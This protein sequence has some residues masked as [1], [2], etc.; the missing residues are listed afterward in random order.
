MK[1][2]FPSI[3]ACG[4]SPIRVSKLPYRGITKWRQGHTP[5]TLRNW[6]KTVNI[7]LSPFLG[8]LRTQLIKYALLRNTPYCAHVCQLSTSL[9]NW[10][11]PLPP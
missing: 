7:K 1:Q 9:R 11:N 6:L 4:T 8:T 2:Q 3:L 10:E 5:Y